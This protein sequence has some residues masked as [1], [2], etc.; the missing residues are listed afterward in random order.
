[1]A[2]QALYAPRSEE[3]VWNI[4]LWISQFAL[5]WIFGIVGVVRAFAPMHTL[6]ARLNWADPG[7]DWFLRGTGYALICVAFALVLPAV[8]DIGQRLVPATAIAMAIVMA[9][10]AASH[11]IRHQPGMLAM[12]VMIGIGCAFVAWGRGRRL[13]V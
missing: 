11:I 13:P 9:V 7:N 8:L 4:T 1:M 10:V 6:Q 5:A 12:D 2:T 3:R